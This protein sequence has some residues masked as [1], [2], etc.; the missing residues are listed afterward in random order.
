MLND[1]RS[2]N[3]LDRISVEFD[4]DRTTEKV[5]RNDKPLG[6]P[7]IQHKTFQTGERTMFYPHQMSCLEE[8]P[9]LARQPRVCDYPNC[10]QFTRIHGSRI[11]SKTDDK[12]HSGNCEDG[13]SL[14]KIEA[15]ECVS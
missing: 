2:R 15:A 7:N 10:I 8:R 4:C 3:G 6:V 1:L 12:I 14:L 11:L 13:Q 5:Y 9:G